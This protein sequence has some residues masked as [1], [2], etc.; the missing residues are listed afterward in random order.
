MI[1]EGGGYD[2]YCETF[3]VSYIFFLTYPSFPSFERHT[4]PWC[5]SV[6]S[7]QYSKA[8]SFEN[9]LENFYT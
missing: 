4:S 6:L 8:F 2:G 3:Y 7:N 9:W 5:A 1:I